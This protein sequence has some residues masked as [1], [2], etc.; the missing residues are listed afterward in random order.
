MNELL[1]QTM[2]AYPWVG[3][4]LM[5]VFAGCVAIV[6]GTIVGICIMAAAHPDKERRR[7]AR[8]ATSPLVKVLRIAVDFVKEF[9]RR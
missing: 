4:V 6:V 8:R 1:V 7:D 5:L 3:A 9:R 2:S